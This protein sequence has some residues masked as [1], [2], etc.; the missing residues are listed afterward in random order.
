MNSG[1]YDFNK[2]RGDQDLT[3]DSNMCWAASASNIIAWWQDQNGIV[4][5]QKQKIPQGADVW[6]TY[7]AVFDNDG[8]NPDKALTWWIT[9]KETPANIDKTVYD[10]TLRWTGIDGSTSYNP[11]ELFDG[12]FLTSTTFTP[13]P[14]YDMGI[15]P[16]TLGLDG[17]NVLLDKA[18]A[19]IGAFSMGYAFAVE[20]ATN[21]DTPASHAIT[22]WGA[23]YTINEEGKAVIDYVYVTESDDAVDKIYKATV[24]KKGYI[25]EGLWA[26]GLAYRITKAV[27]MRS[28][29]IPEP[30]TATL[31]LLALAGLAA[32]RRRA[33]R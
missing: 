27:G 29:P 6:Q 23:G 16:I 30:T 22:L 28:E 14:L 32:R 5:T 8:G 2:Q 24:D 21:A 18:D 10:G 11:N 7:V 15:D 20:V 13:T 3:N 9:G 33:S 4:S 26:G 12:G 1:W 25:C 19:L 31:S 17:G